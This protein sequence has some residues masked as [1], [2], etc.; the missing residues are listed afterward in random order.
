MRTHLRFAVLFLITVFVF[1]GLSAQT[2]IHPGIDMCREDLEFMKN[3][4]LA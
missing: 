1:V 2:F 3:K 4:T